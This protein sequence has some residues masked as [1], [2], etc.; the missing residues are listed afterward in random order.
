MLL[1]RPWAETGPH[2]SLCRFW[3][4]KETP[5]P[6]AAFNHLRTHATHEGQ[7][8]PI[9]ERFHHICLPLPKMVVAQSQPVQKEHQPSRNM[10]SALLSLFS[11]TLKRTE[12]EL[13][14]RLRC[15]V[16]PATTCLVS[17]FAAVS[18]PNCPGEENHLSP[19]DLPR[20]K[21]TTDW[22]DGDKKH[23]SKKQLILP[24]LC[25]SA[26]PS[27]T[28]FARPEA[29]HV[30]KSS[31]TKAFLELPPYRLDFGPL[32]DTKKRRPK[33]AQ[34]HWPKSG[35]SSHRPTAGL[36]HQCCRTGCANHV[37][38]NFRP[39]WRRPRT[40]LEKKTEVPLAA[41]HEAKLLHI[42]HLS[43]ELHEMHTC[44]KHA[45]NYVRK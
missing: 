8:H 31:A 21:W 12:A 18:W 25:R 3:T 11:K 41:Y 6:T 29:I 45:V 2:A 42:D 22:L 19:D 27:T 38:N 34:F 7:S 23:W 35:R 15:F 13:W 14:R 4:Y 24:R 43:S 36:R 10:F 5:H 30:T 40:T 9:R 44:E 17:V 39:G 26:P 37:I 1:V 32:R 33:A 28:A 20:Q 16:M